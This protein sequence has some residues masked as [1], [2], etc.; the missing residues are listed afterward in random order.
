MYT[1]QK[2]GFTLIEL[3]VVIAIIAILA[4]ILFPVFAQAKLAAKKAG[5]LSNNKQI[6]LAVLMYTNDNDDTY[7]YAQPGNWEWADTWLVN[8]QPYIKSFQLLLA[9]TDKGPR[10]DWSGPAY[11]YAGN[12]I[13]CWDWKQGG[14]AVHGVISPRQNWWLNWNQTF[15]T[16]SVSQPAETILLGER[17]SIK[18]YGYDMRGAWDDNFN[19]FY[20]WWFD[21]PGQ[22]PLGTDQWT[23]PTNK[24]GSVYTGYS[25]ISTF[26]FTDGHAAAM[27]PLKTIDGNGYNN[28]N[29]DSTFWKYWDAQ[30]AQ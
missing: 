27:N 11:S 26:S 3:L 6:N 28:G 2:K 20:G 13:V 16:T 12:G 18:D 1:F 5:S 4:A 9:P 7:P 14:W 19:T 10:D 8:T 24:P 30:K 29:C 22:G 15:T 23:K 17:Q 25:G 21:I